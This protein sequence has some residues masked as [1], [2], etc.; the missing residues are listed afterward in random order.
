M[1]Y[2]DD[3]FYEASDVAGGE[4]DHDKWEEHWH[5]DFINTAGDAERFITNTVAS[6]S[7]EDFVITV[8]RYAGR[9]RAPDA[10]GLHDHHSDQL[11]Q[12][13]QPD[14]PARHA[15]Q[16]PAAIPRREWRG[17]YRVT[18]DFGL[19]RGR[20]F[21]R[22]VRT[23]P[24]QC[25]ADPNARCLHAV[26][27][28]AGPAGFD[29]VMTGAWDSDQAGPAFEGKVLKSTSDSTYSGTGTGSTAS[30][31]GS[32]QNIRL[33]EHVY[34][35]GAATAA[36]LAAGGGTF[37]MQARTRSRY[38]V[39]ISEA[40]QDNI[41]QIILRVLESDGTPRGFA[42]AGHSLS[43]SAGSVKWAAQSLHRNSTFP[44]AAADNTLTAVSGCVAGDLLH[45]ETGYRT[46]T[47][48]TT[49]AAMLF[50][51]NSGFDL[52][53]DDN[54][55]SV[56]QRV[57]GNLFGRV[58]AAAKPNR[59]AARRGFTGHVGHLLADR[60]RPR[61]RHPRPR[62]HPHAR[63]VPGSQMHTN[64]GSDPT[65]TDDADPA[66]RAAGRGTTRRAAT[67]SSS[68]TRRPGAA[69]WVAI[70][71][72]GANKIQPQ[73]SRPHIAGSIRPRCPYL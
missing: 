20:P 50:T 27:L 34:E 15:G 72:G 32:A 22:H 59:S 42:Y 64:S 61:A 43:N 4:A 30:G 71:G 53:E 13:A 69:D 60:P 2:A 66:T 16:P 33:G 23:K 1:R 40:A 45:V 58:R 52:P 6:R 8:V 46:F 55:T 17:L 41:S 14:R 25:A 63:R 49:G 9:G 44:P 3:Q 10:G 35:L 24:A 47:V 38:G 57:A 70:S 36:I 21:A 29:P 12:R 56:L 48:G 39:G 18:A 37:R 65:V 67:C 26:V 7:N 68:A 31:G 19:P 54:S 28:L 73:R 5:D 11:G 62:R 51:S